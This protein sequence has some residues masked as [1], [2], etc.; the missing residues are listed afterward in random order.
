[1]IDIDW[2]NKLWCLQQSLTR[3]L[4]A[5][6]PTAGQRAGWKRSLRRSVSLADENVISH[7][8][9]SPAPAAAA[10]AACAAALAAFSAMTSLAG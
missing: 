10:E 2:L 8:P 1:M 3:T 4:D 5:A 9:Y 7:S 6:T